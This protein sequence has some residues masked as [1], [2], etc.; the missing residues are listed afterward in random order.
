LGFTFLALGALS[1]FLSVPSALGAPCS[2]S[3]GRH[4]VCLAGS[5]SGDLRFL[6]VDDSVFT[7]GLRGGEES[8]S[9]LSRGRRGGDKSPLRSIFQEKDF[10]FFEFWFATT[11]R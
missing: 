7:F 9:A 4:A 5:A 6:F 10:F 11:Q 8:S 3:G 1:S 2:V